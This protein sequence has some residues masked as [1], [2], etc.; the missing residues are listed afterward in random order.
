MVEGAAGRD[1]LLL[2][3]SGFHSRRAGE[4]YT[5]HDLRDLAERSPER[6]S[7]NVLLRPAVEAALL[8]TVAYVAGP[9]ELAYLPQCLPVYAAL[10]VEPQ[11]PVPRWSGVVVEA[12]IRKVL[13]RYAIGLDDL[14]L[15]EGQLEQRLVRAD[16]P[17]SAEAAAADLRTALETQYARLREAAVAIDPTL[18]KPVDATR[19][20][21]LTGLR[22]LEKRL[23]AHLKQRNE[24]LVQQ[25]ARARAAL[26]PL[27]RPQERVYGPAGYLVR[28]GRA[29]LTAVLEQAD[30]WAATLEAPRRDP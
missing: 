30:S 9:G 7:P 14:K 29:F 25:V 15:G 23:L 11:L 26:F 1:R 3:G 6:F 24:T 19:N 16:L 10:D 8:P 12:R 18:K 28:Y 17:P 21:A 13:D 5:L 27:G 20:A 22:E 4:R 2:D